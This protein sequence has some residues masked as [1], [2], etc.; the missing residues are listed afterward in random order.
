MGPF[1]SINQLQVDTCPLIWQ[2]KSCVG[3]PRQHDVT[4]TL[5][6]LF[7]LLQQDHDDLRLWFGFAAV[8]I[9]GPR[10]LLELP[11]LK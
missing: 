10:W 7:T 2:D 9:N 4:V 5:L 3:T 11:L 6:A 8:P 1:S